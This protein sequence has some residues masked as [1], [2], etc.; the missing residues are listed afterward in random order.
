M[1]STDENSRDSGKEQVEDDS[2]KTEDPDTPRDDTALQGPEND[3]KDTGSNTADQS[4]SDDQGNDHPESQQSTDANNQED[5]LPAQPEI[6]LP[7]KGNRQEFRDEPEKSESVEDTDEFHEQEKPVRPIIRQG[8]PQTASGSKGIF[9]EPTGGVFGKP[10]GGVFGHPSGGVF[11]KPTGGVFDR[12]SLEA[13]PSA[14]T[15]VDESPQ[16][17]TA[18]GQPDV[19]AYL[20]ETNLV[21]PTDGESLTVENK[22]GGAQEQEIYFSR[23]ENPPLHEER[24]NKRAEA[25]DVLERDHDL[26]EAIA[27]LDGEDQQLYSE[28]QSL[29]QPATDGK[30]KPV[31]ALENITKDST[32]P[33]TS[34]VFAEHLKWLFPQRISKMSGRLEVKADSRGS[35]NRK[36]NEITISPL[37]SK[38]KVAETVLHEAIH[39]IT[40]D[41]VSDFKSKDP[42]RLKN[43]TDAQK[44]SLISLEKIFDHTKQVLGP[45]ESQKH[46]GLNSL[47][48]F[49]SEGYTNK[50]FQGVLKGISVKDLDL[51]SVPEKEK[52]YLGSNLWSRFK[53]E[54]KKLLGID[55]TSEKDNALSLF[56]DRSMD[57]LGSTK[58][59]DLRRQ[60][61]EILRDSPQ[62]AKDFEPLG[63]PK[64]QLEAALNGERPLGVETEE[65]F[66]EFKADVSDTFAKCGL[67]DA[68]VRL[69]GSATA[70]YSDNPGKPLGHHFDR[71]LK[72]GEKFERGVTDRKIAADYDLNITSP[73]MVEKLNS[74]G[75]KIN[76]YGN[77]STFDIREC[78]PDLDRLSEKWSDKYG[79]EVNF[80]GYPEAKPII[81]MEYIICKL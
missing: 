52:P 55:A 64:E 8:T 36:A 18:T 13:K 29:L 7:G 41:L 74:K 75:Y 56:M 14:E 46:Y 44:T 10:T 65:L 19:P 22:L 11:G 21:N 66:K 47:E 70:I 78:F 72:S 50:E 67:G 76:K 20:G 28:S 23:N 5:G 27:H 33:P 31:K 53:F 16:Q 68:E 69:Q 43:L 42:E 59:I 77:Y 49:L 57:L 81:N 62:L 79:R 6:P 34:R 38:D 2:A 40:V 1:D 25:A 35:F 54:Y 3:T 39:G 26:A 58:D 15:H 63:I 60:Q 9:G 37:Q 48:E 30:I 4:G 24:I 12:P 71:N 80:V 17:E 32:L 73:T 51:P 61:N 45:E